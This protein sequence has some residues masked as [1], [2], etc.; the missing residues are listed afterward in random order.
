MKENRI[1]Y[2]L[3]NYQHVSDLH[4]IEMSNRN[5]HLCPKSHMAVTAWS[6]ANPGGRMRLP[7]REQRMK[8]KMIE[9]KVVNHKSHRKRDIEDRPITYLSVREGW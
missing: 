7:E 3:Q 2:F 6:E 5:S 9:E 1:D 8:K 4:K